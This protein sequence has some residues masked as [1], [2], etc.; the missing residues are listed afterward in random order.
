MY[1]VHSDGIQSSKHMCIPEGSNRKSYQQLMTCEYP[2]VV[3]GKG[4]RIIIRQIGN[5]PL[6]LFE[7]K[8]FGKYGGIES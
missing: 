6:K 5:G 4:N 1:V 7:V 2:N 3:T 8:P